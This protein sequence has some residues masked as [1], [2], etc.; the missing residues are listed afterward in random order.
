MR[1]TRKHYDVAVI[2]GGPAGLVSA[3]AFAHRGARVLVLEANPQACRRFA[4]EFIHPPGVGVL[5]SLRIRRSDW[6]H[7]RTSFGFKIFPDDGS[8]PIEMAY[9]QGVALTCAHDTL[10][11]GLREEAAGLAGVELVTYARLA[12]L[13]GHVLRVD[14]RER[15]AQ[16]EVTAARIIGA[17]GR[18]SVVRRQLG[19]EE[20][21]TLLS[22]MASVELRG[23]ELPFE[24]FGHVLL[25]GPGPALLYRIGPDRVRGCLDVPLRYGAAQ[26]NPTFLW[27]AF[28]PVLPP[29][30]LPAFRRALAEGPVTWAANRFRP[31]SDFGRGHVALVGDAL[32]HV[33]PMTAIGLSMGF[34][35]ARAVAAHEDLERYAEERRGYVPE[36]LASALYHCFRR[37]DPSATGVREAMFDVLRENAEARGQTMRILCGQEERTSSFGGIFM[38]IAAEAMNSTARSALRRGGLKSVSAELAAYGEWM[39]WP[40]AS[41]VPGGVHQRYRGRG[42]PTHPIPL[43]KEFIP[44]RDVPRS[45][46]EDGESSRRHQAPPPPLAQA[47]EQATDFLL[48]ELES[49]ATQ[50]KQRP[51]DVLRAGAIRVMRAI[52]RTD[53][54]AGIAARMSL[55]RRH[56]AHEGLRRLLER[57]EHEAP[58]ARPPSIAT[59]DLAG[60]FHLLLGGS[61]WVQEPI[62]GISEGVDV[63]LGCQTVA[64]GFAARAFDRTRAGGRGVGDLRATALAC[65][66]L[67]IIQRRQPRMFDARITPALERAARW[68]SETQSPDGSWA[69]LGSEGRIAATAWAMQALLAAKGPTTHSRLRRAARWLVE[70]QVEDGAFTEGIP[71]QGDAERRWLTAIALQALISVRAPYPEAMEAAEALL[72]TALAEGLHDEARGPFQVASWEECAESLDAL[73]L[74]ETLRRERPEPLRRAASAPSVPSGRSEADWIF[75]KESLGEVS[76][77]F[78]RPIALLPGNL[79]VAMTLGYL[80]CRVADTIE[81]HPSVPL[82]AKEPLFA[83]FLDVLRGHKEPEAFTEAFKPIPGQDAELALSRALPTVM[84]VFH[85]LPE[86]IQA[87]LARWTSE[88]A[89]GMAIYAHRERGTDGLV[90]LHTVADLERYCYFVAGTVGHLTTELFLEELGGEVTPE[91]AQTM[92]LHAEAFGT[93]LQLVNILKDV[94]DDREERGWSFIPRALCAAGGMGVAELTDPGQRARAHATVAPLFELARK[95]LDDGLR[96][97]LAIPATAPQ[98]RLFCLLPL[99]MAARSLV[100][101]RGNDAMF[102]AGQPV[103]IPRTEVEALITDCMNHHADDTTLQAHYA[104]LWRQAPN[105]QHRLSAG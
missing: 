76:R 24:G 78:A 84:R 103:K 69:P 67:K 46:S 56:L 17:D 63:L 75:C 11:E 29:A 104:E 43:L 27:D 77:T 98:L 15:G 94:T 10:V 1:F 44:V 91:Q 7:A 99:W 81:D 101:A 73:A 102:V 88:M 54:R 6:A 83:C 22:Y 25:G 82:A 48:R 31:R 71:V 58:G 12:G 42:T 41:L 65:E 97:A 38:R 35:D 72:A 37:E 13:Q 93:G 16:V 34:L 57:E 20:N 40:A 23:L 86:N 55:W 33:H 100:L 45:E 2:G 39:Q 36:L 74:H 95:N 70:R 80:L 79:E 14:D 51:D 30:L 21:S 66:A 64:G 68:L 60:L 105:H 49:F 96:Y 87:S 61:T 9:P 62:V 90:A 52:T 8:A 92:R 28:S 59:A 47:M 85:T 4:G 18:A 3:I 89:R 32:G 50:L 26:R 5:D 53:M 19:L